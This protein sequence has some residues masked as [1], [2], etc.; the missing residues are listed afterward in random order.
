MTVP[1]QRGIHSPQQVIR[2]ICHTNQAVSRGAVKYDQSSEMEPHIPFSGGRRRSFCSTM[3][4]LI[5]EYKFFSFF[6]PHI[7]LTS[8][9]VFHSSLWVLPFF[10]HPFFF[11]FFE[12]RRDPND[13]LTWNAPRSFPTPFPPSPF[14]KALVL[15]Q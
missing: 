10:S 2:T 1:A 13:P 5:T 6:P 11:F 15:P 8:G 7:L 9:A 4:L 12:D 3:L 14:I